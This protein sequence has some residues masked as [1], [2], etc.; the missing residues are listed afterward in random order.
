MGRLWELG[1]RVALYSSNYEKAYARLGG[2]VMCGLQEPKAHLIATRGMR[3]RSN[4]MD[5]RRTSLQLKP[6][7]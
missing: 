4:E 2:S 5:P 6:V 1:K 7:L 3:D